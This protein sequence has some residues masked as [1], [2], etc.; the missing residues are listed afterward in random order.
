MQCAFLEGCDVLRNL[1]PYLFSSSCFL[2]SCSAFLGR[3]A[4]LKVKVV[5]KSR[6][7]SARAS[8]GDKRAT[9]VI[10]VGSDPPSSSYR[11]ET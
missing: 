9:A 2:A 8:V 1:R 6:I 4:P 3:D 11:V 5:D 7:A 10:A